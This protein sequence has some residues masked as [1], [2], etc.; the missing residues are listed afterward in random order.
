MT[1][2][3][4]SKTLNSNERIQNIY[5]TSLPSKT[6]RKPSAYDKNFEQHLIDHNIY[7]EG[8]EYPEGRRTPEPSNIDQIHRELLVPR[9]SLSPSRV[10]DS[11]FREFK[12][13]AELN[14]KAQCYAT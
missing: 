4:S 1:S 5:A 10:S 9:A 11:V 13:K 2:S 14:R 6:P 3:Q 8:Y 12:Q 7:L